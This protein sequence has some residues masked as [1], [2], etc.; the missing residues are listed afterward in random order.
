MR[1]S[2]L[3]A[4][5]TGAAECATIDYSYLNDPLVG[6]TNGATTLVAV[7][8]HGDILGGSYTVGSGGFMNTF[9]YSNGVFSYLDLPGFVGFDINDQDQ[10]VG[11]M[12]V[13]QVYSPVVVQNNQLQ[14]ILSFPGAT[15]TW[16]EGINNSG[17]VVGEYTDGNDP[18][19]HAF[20]YFNGIY[21]D[22]GVPGD[23]FATGINNL[24]EIVGDYWI[25]SQCHGFTWMNGSYTTL[26]PPGFL[27][28]GF[29]GI[30]D[31]G[32]IVGD[33]FFYGDGVF[34]EIPPAAGWLA[35][36]SSINNGGE[37]VGSAGNQG[38]IA[39]A[40]P[41]PGTFIEASLAAMVLVALQLRRRRSTR[42]RL[43]RSWLAQDSVGC[44]NQPAPAIRE[45]ET[46]E[47]DLRLGRAE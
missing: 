37:M 23:S 9:I 12:Y 1:T 18:P 39:E 27:I 46:L 19:H 3:A 24:G 15:A 29:T 21:T 44:M 13:G 11:S 45:I 25:G 47:A 17:A 38:L 30:N 2:I 32:E 26:D 20:L 8:N 16:G 5:A 35:E 10:I 36:L 34:T 6:S 22:L 41:E 4:F 43:R 31:Q 7:N 14:Q 40:V 28:P 42:L 33:G